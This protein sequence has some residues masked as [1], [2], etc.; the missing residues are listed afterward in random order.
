KE[1]EKKKGGEKK[2]EEKR[3]SKEIERKNEV[4][5]EEKEKTMERELSIEVIPYAEW[6]VPPLVTR[7]DQYLGFGLF[8]GC[9]KTAYFGYVCM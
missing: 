2:E 5:V 6:P 4:K 8:A 3:E 9:Y 7:S 1:K